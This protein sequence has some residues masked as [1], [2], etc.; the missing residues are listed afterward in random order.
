MP[1]VMLHTNEVYGN[2]TAYTACVNTP[3]LSLL[4][5]TGVPQ[6]GVV[7][8]RRGERMQREILWIDAQQWC[9]CVCVCVCC[10]VCKRRG[11][12][13]GGSRSDAFGGPPG[14]GGGGGV[15]AGP[16]AGGAAAGGGRGRQGLCFLRPPFTHVRV[17]Y[18]P[19]PPPPPHT[20]THTH[21]HP[22][23]PPAQFDENGRWVQWI[24][25]QMANLV[26]L[27][28]WFAVKKMTDEDSY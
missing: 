1:S 26:A 25:C 7:R 12:G 6:V 4:N 15:G 28:T 9:V 23:S 16:A 10:V 21:T 18:Q 13:G 8:G 14:G 5:C 2:G 24:L 3:G 17:A 22:P 11:G 20:H 27:G 19:P